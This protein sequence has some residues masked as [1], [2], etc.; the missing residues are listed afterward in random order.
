[1]KILIILTALASLALPFSSPAAETDRLAAAARAISVYPADI[2]QA[3]QTTLSHPSTL[4]Q[5][6]QILA[7]SRADFQAISSR[8][9]PDLQKKLWQ[10]VR[11]PRLLRS[12]T[13]LGPN[14]DNASLI[15]NYPKETQAAAKELA[16]S[17]FDI[18]S[19]STEILKQ[20]LGQMASA[21][22]GL[23]AATQSAF[24]SVAVHS[25]IFQVLNE[26]LGLSKTDPQSFKKNPQAL[27]QEAQKLSGL[28]ATAAPA[29]PP[30]TIQ[31][32]AGDD[33][34]AVAALSKANQEF[35]AKNDEQLDQ[36][37]YSKDATQVNVGYT[38]N[39]AL[40]SPIGWAY[41]VWFG[42]PAWDPFPYF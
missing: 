39:S 11:Y 25:A 1:M 12:L 26:A 5:I 13:A 9:N 32:V 30:K 15:S 31:A 33:P 10:V 8:L 40:Y 37:P 14:G 20:A 7:K 6:G 16:K 18:L 4:V 35:R 24:R 22:Q 27:T 23:P 38:P 21:I 19:Q 29:T 28:I 36:V 42:W 2:R 41:P 34:E 17:H 3:T